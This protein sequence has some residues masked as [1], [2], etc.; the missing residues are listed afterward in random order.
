[1]T[2]SKI[3]PISQ[4]GATHLELLHQME[5]STD[6]MLTALRASN[7]TNLENLLREREELCERIGKTSKVFAGLAS[8]IKRDNVSGRREDL[9]AVLGQIHAREHSLLAKQAQCETILSHALAS[10]REE[11]ASLS[12]RRDLQETYQGSRSAAQDARFLDSKL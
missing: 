12:Q 4:A 1:M 5:A 10:C 2:N 3:D 11:L 6:R 9:E 7:F 8:E